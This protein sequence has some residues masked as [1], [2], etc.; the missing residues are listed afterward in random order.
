MTKQLQSGHDDMLKAR[1]LEQSQTHTSA[2]YY[3]LPCSY[4]FYSILNNNLATL[5]QICLH[6]ALILVASSAFLPRVHAKSAKC[7]AMSA[8]VPQQAALSCNSCMPGQLHAICEPAVSQR[9]FCSTKVTVLLMV[10]ARGWP[11]IYLPD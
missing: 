11:Y 4:C 2:P 6:G 7:P 10:S 1:I 9:N 8:S 5:L 3:W